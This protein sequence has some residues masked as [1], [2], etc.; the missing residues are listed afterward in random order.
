[1]SD[2]CETPMSDHI[3]KFWEL[4]SKEHVRILIDIRRDHD[5]GQPPHWDSSSFSNEVAK[6]LVNERAQ[7]VSQVEGLQRRIA[8]IDAPN[9][10]RA[11]LQTE[12]RRQIDVEGWTPGHDDEHEDG[13]MAQAASLYYRNTQHPLTMREDGAP[14][15]WPW[16]ARWWKPKDA[17]R[18]LVRAGAL[19]LAEQERLRRLPGSGSLKR[20]RAAKYDKQIEQVVSAL[21]SLAVSSTDRKPGDAS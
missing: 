8:S 17:H 3:A 15:G 10:A 4:L 5:E 21:A 14:L 9:I 7:A 13:E 16:D 11:L 6:A 19:Y 20:F 2:A 18:D 12:R 1:M